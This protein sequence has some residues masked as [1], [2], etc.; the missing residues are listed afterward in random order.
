MDGGMVSG[1]I[2]V[3]VDLVEVGRMQEVLERHPKRFPERVFTEA[4]AAYCRRSVHAA[5]R[6]AARFAAKEAVMKALGTGWDRGVAF[7][8]I[9]V[10]RKPSGVPG[11]R[12]TGIARE[13]AERLGVARIDLSLSHSREHAIAMV[14]FSGESAP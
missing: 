10:T 13:V 12:L 11:V 4:E 14:V 1:V 5:E 7:R 9:E 2:G 6:F 3:G 8:D